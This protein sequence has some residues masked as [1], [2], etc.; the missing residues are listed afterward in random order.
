MYR[1]KILVSD[2]TQEVCPDK[3]L[4]EVS[5]REVMEK[6]GWIFN[7]TH[8][9][10]VWGKSHCGEGS[11]FGFHSNAAYG[12]VSTTFKGSG[13]ATLSF[14]NCWAASLYKVSVVING[15]VKSEAEGNVMEKEI[16][17]SF[18]KGDNL[19]IK[20]NGAIIKIN[21]LDITCN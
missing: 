20:E 9:D 19:I 12:S 15:E 3:G 10:M 2:E 4:S 16:S 11:W 21:S 13:T 6:N 7:T 18:N 5:N 17:F 1:N 8:S 14:G